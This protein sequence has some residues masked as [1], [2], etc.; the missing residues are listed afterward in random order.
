MENLFWKKV[1]KCF[2]RFVLKMPILANIKKSILKNT[3]YDLEN[4]SQKILIHSRKWQILYMQSI[5]V[6]FKL[7]HLLMQKNIWKKHQILEKDYGNNYKNIAYILHVI[8]RCL[9]DK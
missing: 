5:D 2:L 8:Q 4:K 6:N 3:K 9:N 1:K 7:V